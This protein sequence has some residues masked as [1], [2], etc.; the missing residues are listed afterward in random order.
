VHCQQQ[1]WD[2]EDQSG[3]GIKN[4]LSPS[5]V[6]GM[7]ISTR[8]AH[9]GRFSLALQIAAT[10]TGQTRMFQVGAALCG[11][12]GFVPTKGRTLMGWM[13]IEPTDTKQTFG[14]NTYFGM[15]AWTE[16]ENALV[17]G[18]PR[19]YGEWFEIYMPIESTLGGEQLLQFAAEGLLATDIISLPGAE[20]WTGFIYLD[21]ILIK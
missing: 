12:Q 21:D 4:M 14:R 7:A 15:R 1:S 10:G 20:D 11:G 19:G 2:F 9:E 17:E 13:Y 16:K 5:A 6:R 18:V 3:G 8:Q